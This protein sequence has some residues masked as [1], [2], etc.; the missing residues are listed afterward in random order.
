MDCVFINGKCW[1]CGGS[2][3]KVV[4]RQGDPVDPHE[5]DPEESP[6]P[7]YPPEYY[8]NG[9]PILQQVYKSQAVWAGTM[10]AT[11]DCRIIRSPPWNGQ[12]NLNPNYGLSFG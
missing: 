5:L 6:P 11:C 8:P 7:T 1:T 9:Y 3:L 4:H 10:Y 2:G 12:L